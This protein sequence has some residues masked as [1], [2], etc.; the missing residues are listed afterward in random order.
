M[1]KEG[2]KARLEEK[3]GKV[4]EAKKQVRREMEELK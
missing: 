3:V 1:E 2:K 4:E